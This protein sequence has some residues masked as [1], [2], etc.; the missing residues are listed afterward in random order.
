MQKH[1]KIVLIGGPGTGKTTII[2]EL[3]SKGYICFN[4]ISREVT[5]EAQKKGIDQLFLKDPILFSKLLLE[6][7]EQ[8][9]VD[10]EKINDSVFFDRGIP[11]V[12]AYL[13]YSEATYPSIFQEKSEQYKYDIIFH[14]SPWKAIHETDN[15]RYENF[16]ETEK[17]ATFL[18]NTYKNLGY[19]LIEVPFGTIKDRTNFILNTVARLA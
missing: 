16:E 15:E 12:L 2:K 6:G 4:E 19:Q 1:K 10:S 3:K 8:Q 17:I 11:D 5:L 18:T 14:F 7:R 13:N 9:Y